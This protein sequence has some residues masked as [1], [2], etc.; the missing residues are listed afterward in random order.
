MGGTYNP[1]GLAGFT[2]AAGSFD[3]YG[4]LSDGDDIVSRVAYAATPIAAPNGPIVKRGTVLHVDIN[5]Q[6]TQGDGTPGKEF[7]CVA[8]E[9]SDTTI[10]NDPPT[11]AVLIYTSGKMKAD[12]IIWPPS[13]LHVQ[14]TEQLRDVGIHIES[15]E[16]TDGSTVKTAPGKKE[17]DNAKA[18][19]EKNRAAQKERKEEAQKPREDATDSTFAYLTPEEREKHPELADLPMSEELKASFS[20]AEPMPG[21]EKPTGNFSHKQPP[22]PPPQHGHDNKEHKK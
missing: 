22:A 2:G 20:T 3:Y 9:D 21:Q 15:V 11:V 17:A 12:A 6:V 13:A 16:F 5:N 19:I 4:L 10:A 14:V 8:A 7:N 18:I 1:L